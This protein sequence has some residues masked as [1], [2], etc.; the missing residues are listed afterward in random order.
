MRR[1]PNVLHPNVVEIDGKPYYLGM[2]WYAYPEAP[3]RAEIQ[4]KADLKGAQS[5]VLREGESALQVGFCAPSLD[6]LP[7]GTVSLAACLADSALQPWLGT[8]EVA[9]G[10]WWYIAVRDH[11]AV[12]P[13]GD[14]LGDEQ[15]VKA[16]QDAHSGFVDWRYLSGTLD[17]LARMVTDTKAKGA[18]L[19]SVRT[20]PGERRRH[21]LAAGAA[22]VIAAA[23]AAGAWYVNDLQEQEALRQQRARQDDLRRGKIDA[24][25]AAFVSP[26]YLTPAPARLLIACRQV[27]AA[28]PISD[29]GWTSDRITCTPAGAT[30]EWIRGEGASVRH[31]PAGVITDDGDKGTQNVA[32]TLLPDAGSADGL[33]KLDEVRLALLAWAQEGGFTFKATP[34][35]PPAIPEGVDVKDLP[36]ILPALSFVIGSKISPLG[37]IEDFQSY[38]GLRLTSLQESPTG[39][40]IEG[41]LYGKR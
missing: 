20:T 29:Q 12:L 31:M 15:Q 8:F 35:P 3:A 10:R 9:P 36:P 16:A 25:K 6:E 4:E 14:V 17:D 30:I 28:T 1:R 33:V 21:V 22:T 41:A 38:P 24:A 23:A 26:F 2:E 40:I 7:K 5:Y 37:M 18:R 34:L 39:W 27:F 19:R 11:N 32:F 13:D